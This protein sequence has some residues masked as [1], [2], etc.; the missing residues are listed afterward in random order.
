MRG[1]ITATITITC[2]LLAGWLPAASSMD[3]SRVAQAARTHGGPPNVVVFLLDD[4]AAEDVEYMPAVQQLLVDQGTTFTR[5]YVPF[6]LCCPARATIFTGLYPHNHRVLGNIAPYGGFTAFNDTNTFATLIDDDYDT[7]FI[8]KYFN[9]YAD[10][11]EGRHYVPPGWD[12]WRGSVEPGT[13]SYMR[14]TLNMN[15]TLRRF[16]GVYST[17]LFGEKGRLFLQNRVGQTDPFLLY[18]S[19]VAPHGG[20]PHELD[21]PYLP[22]PY[23]EP[24]Y[25]NTYLGPRTPDDP[26]FNEEDVSDKRPAVQ[27]QPPLDPVQIAAIGEAIAQ[28]REALQSVDDE[29]E[30]TIAEVAAMGEL[31]NT[32]FVLLSDNGYMNGQHRQVQGK[33][34]A[35]EPAARV[36]LIIRG[37]GVPAGASYDGVTGLQDIAPTILSM[38]RQWGD[39]PVAPMDGRSLLP[40]LK[41]TKDDTRPQ[42]LERTVVDPYGDQLIARTD[43]QSRLTSVEWAMHGIVTQD[44]WKYVEY[45]RE[46]AVELYDL[47]SDPYELENLAGQREYRRV[48]RDL[49][50]L[51]EQYRWCSGTACR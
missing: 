5:N 14:Q 39:Q 49:A 16:P 33:M 26:S 48:E 37:P 8:G 31:D 27:E 23:V 36:P 17:R 42:L 15:G 28:R 6:P 30:A 13:Y 20:A 40:L 38:T 44:R 45:P 10:T 46:G 19:F 47:S 35:Y 22:T 29:I 21:D 18:Q 50:A 3:T 32:Y 4:A 51:L 11:D 1:R 12:M 41:G 24:Q 43:V 25:Q 2:A 9:D 7:A 34:A